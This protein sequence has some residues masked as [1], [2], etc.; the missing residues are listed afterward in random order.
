MLFTYVT[1]RLEIDKDDYNF[2]RKTTERT[3]SIAES[4][5]SR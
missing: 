1:G 3:Q 4:K 2:E 5:K